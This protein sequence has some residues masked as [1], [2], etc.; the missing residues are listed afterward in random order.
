[1]FHE[2]AGHGKCTLRFSTVKPLNK[3]PRRKTATRKYGSRNTQQHQH[4]G[5]RIYMYQIEHIPC[6]CIPKP[7]KVKHS[8]RWLTEPVKVAERCLGTHPT[9]ATTLIVKHHVHQSLHRGRMAQITNRKHVVSVGG[10]LRRTQVCDGTL[11]HHA[12]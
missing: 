5:A 11:G 1:M 7:C 10:G 12:R 3:T 4:G 8:P 2:F 9:V 6:P